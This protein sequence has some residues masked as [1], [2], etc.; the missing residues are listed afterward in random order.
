MKVWMKQDRPQADK[1]WSWM[2][3][4]RALFY[5]STFVIFESQLLNRKLN[6]F[7]QLK[8]EKRRHRG[9]F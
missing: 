2:M 1:T 9:P 6:N 5:N 4:S 7:F 8:K 3:S